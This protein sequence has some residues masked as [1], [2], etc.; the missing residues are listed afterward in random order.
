MARNQIAWHLDHK[1][2]KT[3]RRLTTIQLNFS[4]RL[5]LVWRYDGDESKLK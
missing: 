3:I 2:L 1:L 5:A 4:G